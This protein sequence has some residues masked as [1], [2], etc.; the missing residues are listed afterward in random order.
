MIVNLALRFLDVFTIGLER[1]MSKEH[2]RNRWKASFSYIF[3]LLTQH[4]NCRQSDIRPSKFFLQLNVGVRWSL[5]RRWWRS[6]EEDCHVFK[7]VKFGISFRRF[8][9]KYRL[10]LLLTPLEKFWRSLFGRD[11]KKFFVICPKL[12]RRIIVF[13]LQRFGGGSPPFN[14]LAELTFSY[15]YQRLVGASV[16]LGWIMR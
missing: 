2:I 5:L 11:V 4:I 13:M 15:R 8:V 1:V 16:K 6:R 9:W 12:V 10:N 7:L 14:V 3:G